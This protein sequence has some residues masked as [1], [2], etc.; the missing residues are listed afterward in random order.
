ML[1]FDMRWG[2]AVAVLVLG[3]AADAS[4]QQLL[5]TD[6]IELHGTARVVTSAA[7]TCNVLEASHT[8]TEY[9]RMQAN[10]GQPLDVWQ[11]DFS[12]R[13]GSGRWL[14]HL[15]ALYG[16]EARRPDCTNWTGPTGT[17]SEPVQWASTPWPYPRR[18]AAMWWRRM[19]S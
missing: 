10:H 17:Y 11:L 7:G 3:M 5:E 6:G 4:A 8:A 1:R 16:I 15:I 13:N 19:R 14:D 9:E 2:M 12:V 18:R